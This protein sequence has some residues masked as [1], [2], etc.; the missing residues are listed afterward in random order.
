MNPIFIFLV[1]LGGFLVLILC[2][3]IFKSVGG[4]VN[5]L[6]DETKKSMQSDSV[7]GME[8]NKDE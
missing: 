3:S 7:D 5:G 2:N 6:I 8:E 1:I 4:W